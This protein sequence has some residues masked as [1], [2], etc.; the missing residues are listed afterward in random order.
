M[1]LIYV[2]FQ[3]SYSNIFLYYADITILVRILY[4]LLE[5]SIQVFIYSKM[6]KM[7]FLAYD[8]LCILSLISIISNLIKSLDT[9][10]LNISRIPLYICIFLY[11][12]LSVYNFYIY[13]CI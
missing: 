7:P 4:I 5:L 9:I 8:K 6:L 12:Y 10:L 3:Y 11:T 2:Y 13:I 1:H